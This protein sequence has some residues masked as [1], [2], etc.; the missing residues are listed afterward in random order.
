MVIIPASI[1]GSSSPSGFDVSMLSLVVG[2]SLLS[3]LF[4]VMSAGMSYMLLNVSSI[5]PCSL[6]WMFSAPTI[7]TRSL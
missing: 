5:C 7:A 6:N 4:T 1:T 2:I 3:E